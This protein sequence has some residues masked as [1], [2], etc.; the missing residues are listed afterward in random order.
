M[1]ERRGEGIWL[2]GWAQKYLTAGTKSISLDEFRKVLCLESVNDAAG[3]IIQEAPL[4]LWANFR[5]RALD[6]AITEINA[7]TDLRIKLALIE[8]SKHLGAL[9]RKRK[10]RPPWGSTGRKSFL[11]D[12]ALFLKSDQANGDRPRGGPTAEGGNVE[13]RPS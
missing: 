13:I 12:L 11:P 10:E 6:V 1:T 9:R 5:Q 7:K 8:R 4:Q 2:Y 3:N